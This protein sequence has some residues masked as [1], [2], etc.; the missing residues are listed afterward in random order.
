MKFLIVFKNTTFCILFCL[1]TLCSSFSYAQAP[2]T[3]SSNLSVGEIDGNQFRLS[4]TKGDGEKRIIILKA[5]S[6][7][8]AVPIDGTDYLAGAFGT[9]N[10]IAPGEFVVY[11]GNSNTVTITGLMH[12]T[13]YYLKIFE[14]NGSDFSTEYLTSSFLE[15]NQSTLTNPTIQASNITFSNVLG[16]SMTVNWTNGDGEGRLLIARANSPVDVEP[17]D[18]VNYSHSSSSFGD[19]SNEI[20][21]GNY[22][23]YRGPEVSDLITNL[24]PNTTY[25]FALFE[26]NGNKGK[27]YL[28]S[29]SSTNPTVGAT[30]NQITEAYPTRNANALNFGIIDG[31]RL[32]YFSNNSQKG[33]GEKRIV[34]VKA[35]SP[36]TSV[37]VDGVSYT[38]SS[39]FGDGDTLAPDEFVI[40]NGSGNLNRTLLNLQPFTTYYF[41]VFEYNGSGTETFY[42]TTNDSNGDPVLEATQATVSYPT[43]QASNITF[44]N[45]LGSSMTVNWTNG[46]GEGR[47]L[48]ARANSPVDVEPQDLV[49]Y[50]HSSSSFGDA[51]NEI[52][53]GNYVLY[54]G[55]EVS[56][57]ITNLEPNTTYHFALFEYNGNKGKVY[58][59][60]TSSTNPT[61]GATANQI[62]EAY[63]TRNANALN[64]GIIDGNR[65][66]YFSNNSQ[67]GNGE[68]RIVIVKAGSPVTSVPVDGVSYTA[69]STFGDGDTL[70]PDE[71]V[72]YNGSGNFNRTLLN[73]QPFTT[74]YFKV[75]EYN[76]S[77]TETF[78]LTT[79]DSNGDPVLEAT[80][81]TIPYPTIQT[82]SVFINSKT[83]TSFNVNWTNG[84]GSNR[85]LIA[86]AN[87]AVDVEPQ[88][89]VNYSGLS[90][91]YGN[92]AYEI[93]SGNY[94]VYTGNSS[95]NN[96]FNLQPGTNYHF[97]LFE[98]NGNYGKAYLRPGYTFEAET[99]GVTPTTQV[100]NIQ[101]DAIGASSMLVKFTEG[102]GS[103]R[104]V[105]AKEGAPVDIAPIDT[106]TYLADGAF[107]QGEEIGT[108]NYVV[109]N[110]SNNEFQ[111][112]NLNL[113]TN[114]HFAFFEYAIDQNGELYL[115]PGS[116]ASQVTPDPP[117]VASSNLNFA[118][119]CDS[120]VV[121]DWTVGNGEGRL[122]VLSEAP[123]NTTP[124]NTTN[125][126][127][128]FDYGL[129]DAI[130]NGFV[131]FK[132]S[133]QLV[134]PNLL[135]PLTN[136]YTNIY[137]Y[138]GTEEDP[139]FNLTP[140]Q[141]VIGDIIPPDVICE[142]LE[143]ILDADGNGS[144]T[145]NAIGSNSTDNCEIVTTEIDLSTFNCSHLGENNVIFTATDGYGNTNSCVSIVT[146][147]DNIIPNVITQDI[148]I[149]LDVNGNA[150][151]ADNTVDNGSTDACGPLTF[152]TDTTVFSCNTLGDNTVM[153]TV[154][155]GSGNQ[156]T[157]SAIVT[158]EDIT[159]P[160]IIT[161]DITIQL[162]VNGNATIADNAV[163]NG[164]TDACGPLTFSTDTTVFS[165]NTLGD[166]TVML[167]VT[168]GSG[169]QDTA[170]AIVTVEDITAPNIITQ[171]ITI[172]L[173]VNGNAT[174]ADNAVD[175]GSTDACGPLTFSTDTTVFSCNTLGDNT[176]MLTV[177]DGSGNQETASA[178]V[179]VEDITAPN[180]ITQDITIQLDV[181]G[182]ATIADNT[183][184]NGS[185]DA[186]GPLTFSTDTTVFSC[187]T[188]GDNTVMLTVTDGSGN[189]D[190]ASAI[191]TVEDITAPNIIT[192]DITIQLDVNGNATIADNAVDNGSTD[193]CGPLTFSIDTTVFSC[194][195][196]GDNTVML[197]VTDGSGNQDT[198]SAI[199]TVEDITA[200]NIITQD[201]TIQLDVNGN[202]TIADNAVDNG[203]TDACGPL[204]F[205]TDTTVFSCN[206]LG[207]NTV[208]L[209]VTD[210][211]GNQETASAIVTVEDITA[212]NIIT[213]DITIQ[214][215]VNGNATIADNTV[216]NGSTDACGPLTFS[217]DTTVFSCNTLGDNTVMLTVT[218]GSGNQD[219]ASAI[220]TVEDITAP[221]II[222]QD[223]T[224]Q[225]D[226]NGNATIADNA[227]D[228]G[229]TDAC[230]PLTFST[231]TTVFSC[232]TLG[233]N[234]VMLTV[235]DGSGNQDTAS[236]I[237]TVEDIL[238]PTIIAADD[239][240]ADTSNGKCDTTLTIIDAILSDN[241]ESNLTWSMVGGVTDNGNG[242]IGTFTFPL[243]ETTINYINTDSSGNTATDV[244]V[245]NVV[246]NENPICQTQDITIQL[247]END[248]ATIIAADI[249]NGSLDN[250]GIDTFEVTPSTFNTSNIGENTVTLIII[251][252]E[253]NRTECSAIVT[254]E[255][256]LLSIDKNEL[257]SISSFPNPFN[258]ELTF[259]IPIK[260]QNNRFKILLYDLNGKEIINVIK[261]PENNK[262]KINNLSN[263]QEGL[264]MFKIVN[265]ENGN[266]VT[267]KLIKNSN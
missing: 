78:Y 112:L 192:Q 172:Q 19:A 200:P 208:M 6:Q 99:Y 155:D 224:I 7:V 92:V 93:G 154:T 106:I 144:I 118:P 237:V 31:N 212:P 232:N 161:Q 134:P 3:S 142:N 97:A 56:D 126:T 104:L 130:G 66:S 253:G 20:G 252:F 60:S 70:A 22:V 14:F 83:T 262:L 183:V 73:L 213:Q 151:I 187:N 138:N 11:E 27:V 82:S 147:I 152:S 47:L 69:S 67:K 248:I 166:N 148:T 211:S 98:Y 15:G 96:V 264:Y 242:Q 88:D 255:N 136:Y 219:T 246:D 105:I 131:I 103:S 204:T 64:F 197:T 265:T 221:N 34:I 168:D 143:V 174:I 193:A 54:R 42:L 79:N 182:N 121:L 229:S 2:T 216:D 95:S 53:T 191:V 177:T 207:D 33:N 195:T 203:S 249:D 231:D 244:T 9:G 145:A 25:H 12:S 156:D 61:V 32:S 181:N 1:S 209:T 125:Y 239:I 89:L 263:L 164:S 240:N 257:E 260:F 185:T 169:N 28:T 141:G 210:G 218:D 165:C 38:A 132:G 8:T 234:T 46:D 259:V 176:V 68:K 57:L 205:S 17:Q 150:T 90:G 26:Y 87:E 225:L 43:I 108:N 119:P 220:V 110:G 113:S 102:N 59:T 163:D 85:I 256:S 36:V 74:Y 49:N 30:A 258:S 215:D 100:S 123:L 77:G 72:I 184:D 227:V 167:T 188:L 117:T 178:I 157:A 267:R 127:A 86:R 124:T 206:T 186:C 250:C 41:K 71:F 247:D 170:S 153:L 251:D 111:L 243:G 230:G 194:N 158:V 122:V 171:D 29:T 199:V 129:G 146:V 162:D 18:L 16:S 190:T 44:S 226:V 139:I 101:F 241:C 149:Q 202:A 84:D 175:N 51:S 76:G 235:T 245:V 23:L 5:N 4:L 75:F 223:I 55:P 135:Q 107:G 58:L 21:T 45:V 196:L 65:L 80:Q 238:I 159:A 63:P 114:Y 48:I 35:G 128:S 217:T 173:D 10:E 140:L 52:G 13:T 179:T 189:Q 37:P 160:N 50:S 266:T 198:A 116:T 120:N 180:I 94:V 40:Y 233:D 133:G 81:A 91:G 214:L 109:Y 137:E 261:Q 236:A 222:T 201:I 62:T 24:E 115:V 254:V 39:T 228:N